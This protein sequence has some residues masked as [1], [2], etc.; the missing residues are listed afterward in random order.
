MSVGYAS[1]DRLSFNR[2]LKRKDGSTQMNW[3]AL[4]PGF[5]PQQI[6]GA[7]G[8]TDPQIIV[9]TVEQG[10]RPTAAVVNFALHPAIL[11]G[12]N[13]LYSADFP[14][15]LAEAMSRTIGEHFTCLFFNGCCGNVAAI[16]RHNG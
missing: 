4:V 16:S 8:T 13:W 14:G 9:L 11:A 3:D 1:E 10:G 7:W 5:D 15:Y 2:R 6:E 12:D